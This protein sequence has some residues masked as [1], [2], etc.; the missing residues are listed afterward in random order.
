[1]LTYA[2]YPGCTQEGGSKEYDISLRLVCERLGIELKELEDWSCCGAVHTSITDPL[3]AM[4]LPARNLA[5]VEAQELTEVVTPCNGCYKN[6]RS[7]SLA[8]KADPALRQQVNEALPDHKLEGDVTVKHPL[9]VIVDDYGLDRL[10]VPRP[11]EGLRVACYY[12]CVLTRPRGEFDSPEKPQAMDKLMRALGAEPVHFPYKA[13]CCGGAVL[14][15]HTHVAVDLSAKVLLSAKEAGADCVALACG[16][17]Q[18][19]LDLYQTWA[20]KAAGT[21]F[22]LPILYFTQLMAL[23]LGVE[24]QRLGFRRHVVSPNPL[25]DRMG[26]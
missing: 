2:Y 17:C 16:M 8:I 4:T 20:E 10:E 19:A 14:L 3:L 22:D 6:F 25:L 7:A 26:F 23:A 15:S 18:V 12:G 5:L 11:L 9:Y 21:K 13:K 24:R 1:M